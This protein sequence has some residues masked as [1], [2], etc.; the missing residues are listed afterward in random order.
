[1][2]TNAQT[3]QP[4]ILGQLG[5][6][7]KPVNLLDHLQGSAIRAHYWTS[8]DPEKR[9]QQLIK[10]YN[11]QLIED[12]KELEAAGIDPETIDSYKKRYEGLFTS[13]LGAKS[14][15]FSAMI[16]GPAKFPTRRHEKANRSEEN[17]YTV[18][19]EWRKRAKK[20][21]IRKAQPEKTYISEL[22]RYRAEL[23]GMQ[24]NHDLMKQGN[25][26]IAAAK[27]QG[28]D[29]SGELM[30]LLNISKFNAEW[31]MK[32][33]FGLQNN[34]ANMK[35][36]EGMIKTLEQ[37]ESMKEEN[38]V[39]NYT[40]E[41]G[42]MVIDYNIDRIQIMFDTRP[43]SEELTAWKAKGLNSFNWSPSAV[44]W[45]RKITANALHAVKRML[46]KIVK[47]S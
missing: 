46:D 2:N 23:A 13:W 1:M 47:V 45:Q 24:R 35:R 12:I 22:E 4:D 31:A 32:W 26:M 3:N 15:T 27:K 34:N 9:G 41:G 8:F 39:T 40:F 17:H 21:I 33:G 5:E 18:F 37:K 10:D 16:T 43:T 30:T 36:V 20:A 44:A 19:Q 42:R 11:E 6:I 28:K 25:K 7:L 14:R 29:I 38:P